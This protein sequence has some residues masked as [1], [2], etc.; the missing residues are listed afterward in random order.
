MGVTISISFTRNLVERLEKEARKAGLSLEEYVLELV[1][2][3]LDP[4]ERAREYIEAAKHLLAQAKE[5]LAK[6]DVRQAAEKLWGAAALAVKAY[7]DWRDGKILTSHGELWEYKR[8]LESE[9]GDWVYNVWAVAQ[10][11]HTCFYE[12]WCNRSDVEKAF[13]IIKKLVDEVG[14]IIES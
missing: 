6:N 3:G 8:K 5:E 13:D 4:G 10:S 2:Q 1:L 7:A 12:G 11:M 14:R 9:L